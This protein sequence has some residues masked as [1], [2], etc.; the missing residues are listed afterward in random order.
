[1]ETITEEEFL[2][3]V[4]SQGVPM[5]QVTFECPHC[6]TLQSMEDLVE[7]EAGET[8]QDV[9][10][11]IGFSCIGRFN[12]PNGGGCDWTL[13]GLFQ[14]HELLVKYPDGGERPWFLPKKR[15]EENVPS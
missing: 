12:P 10:K 14:I 15:E 8:L 5:E 7:A 2:E 3:R 1:M 4:K 9:N 11:Y 6:K 13:G